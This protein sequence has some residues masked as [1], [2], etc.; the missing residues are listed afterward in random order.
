[1]MMKN[2]KYLL[3]DIK[4]KAREGAMDLMKQIKSDKNII[5]LRLID[6]KI[7]GLELINKL[8]DSKKVKEFTKQLIDISTSSIDALE[9]IEKVINE[10]I[11]FSA[12]TKNNDIERI[13]AKTNTLPYPDGQNAPAIKEIL[14][15]F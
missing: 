6:R 7:N 10:A 15:E 9:Q 1:M 4:N 11:I 14:L 2:L 5:E 8:N 3:I 13:I 12:S